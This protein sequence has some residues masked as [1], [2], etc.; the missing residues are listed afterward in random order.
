MWGPLDAEAVRHTRSEAGGLVLG[1]SR[2]DPHTGL[3]VNAL[4]ACGMSLLLVVAGDGT[5][6]GAAKNAASPWL[7]SPR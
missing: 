1:S 4:V 7:S 2:G 3:I 6:R 5:I